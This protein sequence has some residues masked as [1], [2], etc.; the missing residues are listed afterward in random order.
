[1]PL[2]TS[3]SPTLAFIADSFLQ[4]RSD[5]PRLPGSAVPPPESISPISPRDPS[6]Q[7]RCNGE[8]LPGALRPGDR[9]LRTFA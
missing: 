1:V 7:V 4:P 5:S 3:Q 8:A 2:I 9:E 6:T